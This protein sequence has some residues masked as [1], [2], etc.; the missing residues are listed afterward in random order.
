MSYAVENTFAIIQTQQF[1]QFRHQIRL[2]GEEYKYLFT[3]ILKEDLNFLSEDPI[4]RNAVKM[5]LL[6][7]VDKMRRR[8]INTQN[9][10]KVQVTLKLNHTEIWAL[11]YVIE[12]YMLEH[13][14]VFGNCIVR[15]ILAQIDQN[16]MLL[17]TQANSL[18]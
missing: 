12:N 11:T 18:M 15:G 13:K 3:I 4:T 17:Q 14:D 7:I 16:N 9:N 2:G 6:S 5:Q 10:S 1:N 8:L